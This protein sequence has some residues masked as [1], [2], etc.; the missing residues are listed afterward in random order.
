MRAITY[1]GGLWHEGNPPL[2]GAMSHAT[3]ASSVVVDG[4]RAF[5]GCIPD[6]DKHC[7]RLVCSARALGLSPMLTAGEIEELAR[8]AVRHFPKGAELYI[9]PIFFAEEGFIVPLPES[10]SFALSVFEMPM[11]SPRGVSACLSS[12]R[13]P[14]PAMA[15]VE[16]KAACLFPNCA[17]ALSEALGRGFDNAV[18]L[19]AWDNVAELANANLFMVRDG[20]VLT[21]T[22]NGTFLAGITRLRVMQ[23]LRQDSV[24]VHERSLTFA[25]LM[26][27]E[28]IFLTGNH[29]KVLPLTRLEKRILP[30]G[31]LYA[32][33]RALYWDF[34]HS[35]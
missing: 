25:D 3:T 8:E 14:A 26:Q 23:L 19:D 29:G 28:E 5:E 34:A 18:L 15:P 4:A 12:Y 16:A 10:T 6:L 1:I 17:R 9:R 35:A 30:T 7:Q 2:L 20:A 31:P 27:A 21:P 32:R 11:P 13:W 24:P 33:A 22:A